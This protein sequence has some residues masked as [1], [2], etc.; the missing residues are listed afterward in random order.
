VCKHPVVALA[1]QLAVA[2]AI[3][4]T[5]SWTATLPAAASR[6][7]HA[8]VLCGEERWTVKTLQDRPHLL[9]VRT[10]TLR[11]LVT[12]PKPA[13]LPYTRLP[14]ERHVFRV[15]AAFT[16]IRPEDDGDYHLILEAGGRTMIAE[17]PEVA[18]T[19]RA[20]PAMRSAMQAARRSAR[21]CA[22][23]AITGVVFFDYYHG[24]DGVA[25]NAIELHPV[26][27]FRCLTGSASAGGVGGSGSA[28]GSSPAD[29][30]RSAGVRL[31]AV[32]SPVR[33]GSDASLTVSVS[34]AQTCSITVYYKSGPSQAAGLYPLRGTRITWT[35]TVGS[36][37]TPGRW[38]ILVS[39]GKAGSL[40]TSFVVT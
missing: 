1:R 36:R 30:S 35:W 33:A 16:A 2:V 31:V 29:G 28:G 9:P 17:T 19:S 11:Y 7:A 25:P 8:R 15:V 26:L 6:D 32:T 24:Q 5:V 12:L 23:A 34:P 21:V 4:L 13:S 20:T 27:G 39:C 22:R 10:V 37:T 38:P 40:R 18:C 3:L 14:F